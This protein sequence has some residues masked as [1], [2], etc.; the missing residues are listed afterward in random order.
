MAHSDGRRSNPESSN[1]R[2]PAMREIE[3]EGATE[4]ANG[5]ITVPKPYTG[6]SSRES[7]LG[8]KKALLSYPWV[9]RV[10]FLP[11]RG[12]SH[13]RS[14]SLRDVRWGVCPPIGECRKTTHRKI[15]AVAE[16][17]GTRQRPTVEEIT[18][19]DVV[20]RLVKNCEL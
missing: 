7:R 6:D 18:I 5:G 19:C 10:A 20:W 15:H 11:V 17:A 13:Y 14:P 3:R 9:I 1:N 2:T 16:L 4:G 12:V 8:T